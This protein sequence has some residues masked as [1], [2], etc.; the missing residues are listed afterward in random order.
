MTINAVNLLPTITASCS[1]FGDA[2]LKKKMTVPFS[3]AKKGDIVLYDFN[4]NGTSDHT[5]I[6]YKVSGNK[7]F[8]VEGNT[9][10]DNTNGGEVQKRVRTKSVTNY[11]VRIKYDSIVTADMVVAT[12]LAQVGVK[13]SPKGS[14]KVKYNTWFY[15]KPV[16]GD[17]Y[18]WCMVFVDWCFAH[19]KVPEPDL[20]KPLGKYGGDIAKPTLKKGSKGVN[21]KFLQKFLNW[22]GCKHLKLDGK[23]GPNTETQLKRFQKAEGIKIDG[24]YGSQ[25][26]KKAKAYKAEI[27]KP[28]P[29]KEPEPAP[30]KKTAADKILE[31]IDRLA[32]PYGTP[33]KKYSYK[34]GRP[35]N[36]CK[37]AMQ[38]YG[39]DTKAEYSDCGD[40]VNT[41]VR[42][43]GVDK[44]FTVL[45]AV[46]TPFPKKEDKFKIVISGRVPK[47][48]ELK[49]GDIIRYKKKGGDQHAMF[50]VGKNKVCDAGHYNRFGNIRKNEFR[51]KRANVKKSTIQVLRAKG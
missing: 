31:V 22:Y 35:R 9:G 19:V 48:K 25:S 15:G 34:T 27:K 1:V 16:H 44:H 10:G 36:K 7:I 40:F 12:A 3:K 18:P 51:Y 45:H 33:K 11:V 17:D 4:G 2:A 21:V 23:F 14:N 42:Q 39:Y 24:V 49:P 13:E 30:V 8:T 46:K 38:K 50:Y 43:S 26:Y 41:V 5:G 6:I 28:D 47:I 32:W 37:E 20:K 29:V